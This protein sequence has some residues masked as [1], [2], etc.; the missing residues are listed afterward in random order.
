M[1]LLNCV[2]AC[3]KSDDIL[4]F[5]CKYGIR[6]KA[7]DEVKKLSQLIRS[8][9]QKLVKIELSD[10]SLLKQPN[11]NQIELIRKILTI[12]FKDRIARKIP[13]SSLNYNNKFALYQCTNFETPIKIHSDS[14]FY[15]RDPEVVI[16]S[17][18]VEGNP[19]LMK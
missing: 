12:C 3:Q 8:Q 6:Y 15:N 7:I 14:A 18:L 5:C 13:K 9:I 19:L 11:D 17:E 4:S 16:F 10:I 1:I 2:G